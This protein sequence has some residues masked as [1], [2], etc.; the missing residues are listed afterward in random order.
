[1]LIVEG[2]R[3]VLELAK[4]SGVDFVIIDTRAGPDVLSI[5]ASLLADVTWLVLEE[6]RISWRSSLNFLLQTKSYR[7]RVRKDA[8][9]E[10]LFWSDKANF[11]FL[12]NKVTRRFIPEVRNVLSAYDFLPAIHLDTSFVVRYMMDPFEAVTM[13]ALARSQFGKSVDEALDYWMQS[14]ELEHDYRQLPR[15]VPP[16]SFLEILRRLYGEPERLLPMLALSAVAMKWAVTLFQYPSHFVVEVSSLISDALLLAILLLLA[17][18][19]LRK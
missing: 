17:R 2:L 7:D 8:S 14:T 6:D 13:G 10:G 15:S 3:T 5:S 1:M 19:R 9:W 18:G 16:P 4:S 11:L 12:P